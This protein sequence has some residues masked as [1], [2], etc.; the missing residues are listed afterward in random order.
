[1]TTEALP[2]KQVFHCDNLSLAIALAAFN[3]AF[4]NADGKSIFGLNKYTLA[5]I[6][7]HALYDKFKGMSHED[8]V[9]FLW[10]NGQPGNITYCFERS[11]VLTAVCEGWDEQGAVGDAACDIDS[12]PKDAG[13]IAR[14]LAQTRVEFIGSKDTV[15]LWRRKDP[16]GNLL[17]PAIAHTVGSSHTDSTGNNATRTTIRDA[18]MKAV[19]V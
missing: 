18:R 7:G 8:A 13:R 15:P 1:M 12:D 9:R 17:V 11:P 4:A 14:R 10:R 5:F 6:R 16:D 2:P 19:Q 3:C